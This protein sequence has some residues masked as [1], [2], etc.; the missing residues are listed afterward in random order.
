VTKWRTLIIGL[1]IGGIAVLGFQRGVHLVR[2]LRN[3]ESNELMR[4]AYFHVPTVLGREGGVRMV[5]VT[6]L[7]G[8]DPPT[9]VARG[10]KTYRVRMIYEVYGQELKVINVVYRLNRGRRVSPSDSEL[11]ALDRAAVRLPLPAE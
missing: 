7:S 6:T 5:D 1:V 3:R 8:T 10:E 11:K 2:Y 9:S 4:W